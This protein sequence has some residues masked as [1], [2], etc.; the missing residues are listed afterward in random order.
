[1]QKRADSVDNL[2]VSII[3]DYILA[4]V[5][6]EMSAKEDENC[7]KKQICKSE[8]YRSIIIF[9]SVIIVKFLIG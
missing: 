4:R 2:N 8:H 1:M 9:R 5:R 7:V 6:A 3:M